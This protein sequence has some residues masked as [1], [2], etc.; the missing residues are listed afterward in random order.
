MRKITN[1]NSITNPI[2]V[3]E[4]TE[5]VYADGV[6]K[7][8]SI[9]DVAVYTPEEIK[10]ILSMSRGKTYAFLSEVAEK[11]EPFRVIRIGRLVRVPKDSFDSWLAGNLEGV[12]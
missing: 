4:R 2:A 3:G 5:V 7:P 8:K 1:R 12:G 11:Q 6:E 9:D 10:R